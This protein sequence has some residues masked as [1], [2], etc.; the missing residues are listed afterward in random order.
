MT[1]IMSRTTPHLDGA[2]TW[3]PYAYRTLFKF[4]NPFKTLNLKPYMALCINFK[5]HVGISLYG[6]P[7]LG[8]SKRYGTPINRTLK[9]T[10][11]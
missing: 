6:G 3:Q 1:S 9:G 10:P 2:R 8:S 11:F 7:F 5:P 4:A